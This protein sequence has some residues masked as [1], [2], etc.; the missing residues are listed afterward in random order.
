MKRAFPS[1]YRA[2]FSATVG[3]LTYVSNVAASD[4]P[5]V[6]VRQGVVGGTL[7]SREAVLFVAATLNEEE[8]RGCTGALIAPNLVLTARHCVSAFT[9]GQYRCTVGGDLDQSVTRSPANAGEMGLLFPPSQIRVSR[10]GE[11]KTPPDYT[12]TRVFAPE[13]SVICRN[14]IALLEVAKGNDESEPEPLAVRLDRGVRLQEKVTAVGFGTNDAATDEKMELEGLAI[15]AIGP[16]EFYPSEGASLPRTF[17]VG[18]GPCPGDSGGPALSDETGAVLGVYSMFRGRCMS[19]EV[20]NFYTQAAP[21]RAFFE[22]VAE[23]TGAELLLEPSSAPASG[24]SPGEM[25]TGG[26]DGED[27]AAT[28]SGCSYSGPMNAGGNALWWFGGLALSRLTRFLRSGPK[29][30]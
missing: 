21:F 13:T 6:S 15:L 4:A 14:D 9:D 20:R 18:R 22:Q 11:K 5:P 17:V 3:L 23:Q 16:S 26:T 1:F 28:A 27:D 2:S 8:G 12:V 7:S 25:P 29:S 30:F 19:D 10:S 24:G